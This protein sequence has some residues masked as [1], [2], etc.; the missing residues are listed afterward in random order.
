[1]AEMKE[2][3]ALA[4]IR[5][6]SSVRTCSR[7]F[8][9]GTGSGTLPSRLTARPA[10]TSSCGGAM[11]PFPYRIALRS[12]SRCRCAALVKKLH[13]QLR[14]PASRLFLIIS[15][16]ASL[17]S[18]LRCPASRLSPLVRLLS[19]L[20]SALCEVVPPL[21]GQRTASCRLIFKMSR[22]R[23]NFFRHARSRVGAGQLFSRNAPPSRTRDRTL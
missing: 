20:E 4:S 3:V 18:F 13:A 10:G 15:Y 17:R 23:D 1:M 8:H 21:P 16:P 9:W 7:S 5:R 11:K 22:M 2:V 12:P 19:P 14:C 6:P